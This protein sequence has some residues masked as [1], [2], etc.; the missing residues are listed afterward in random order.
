MHHLQELP[1]YRFNV[2]DKQDKEN[3][4]LHS[5]AAILNILIR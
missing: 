1:R 3:T 5:S 2:A 4:H